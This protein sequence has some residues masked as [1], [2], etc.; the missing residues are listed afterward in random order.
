[1]S[2]TKPTSAVSGLSDSAPI[3]ALPAPLDLATFRQM[4]DM[5][6]EAFYLTDADGRFHYVNERAVTL[7]GYTRDELLRMNLFDLD[8]EFPPERFAEVVAALA[9]G[10]LPPFEARTRRKDGSYRP[11]EASV[12]RIDVKGK[13]YLFG[14]VRDIGDHKRLEAVQKGFAQRLLETLEAERERVARE[15]HDD[16][17]Q[18]V[19]TVGVL[20][21]ALEQTQGAVPE[22][23]RPL[24]TATHGAI[25]QIT[26]LIARIVRDR[27]PAELLSLG[28]EDTLRSHACEFAHRHKLALR[29]ATV[30]VAGLLPPDHELHVYRIV[31]EA[32]TNVA[33]HANARRVWVLLA[34]RRRKLVVTVRDDGVGFDPERPLRDGFGLVTV[35]ERAELLHA[36]LTVR[37]APGHGT[38]IRL[39]VPLAGPEKPAR[40]KRHTSRPRRKGPTEKSRARSTARKR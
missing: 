5:S 9:H 37:A 22:E 14:V 7:T 11:T 16:V 15:L 25:K 33:H 29:L 20:L 24:L 32:L 4:A 6:N 19:A 27:H 1:L 18:A 31:Q 21:H 30:P 34:R 38:E 28:L 12:A 3:P 26:E 35:R 2:P 13:I 10:P 23:T 36:E 39:A 40:V 17:G 8:P